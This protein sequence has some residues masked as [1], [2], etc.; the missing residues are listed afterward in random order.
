[1]PSKQDEENTKQPYVK[2]KLRTIEL[3]AEEVLAEGCKFVG[4]RAWP[5]QPDDCGIFNNCVLEGS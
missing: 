1:M 2:P 3:S 4:G 5:G